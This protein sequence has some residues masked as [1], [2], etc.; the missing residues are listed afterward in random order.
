MLETCRKRV[1]VRRNL[2]AGLALFAVAATAP[3]LLHAQALP[4]GGSPDGVQAAVS[5]SLGDANLTSTNPFSFLLAGVGAEVYAP[6][7]RSIGAAGSFTLLETSNSGQ[8][9]PL[10]LIAFT[11]GPRYTLRTGLLNGRVRLYGQ[12]LVGGVEG[13]NGLFPK[14]GGATTGA[15]SIAFQT[16]GGI[17]IAFTH[18]TS[19][20]LVQAEWLR[21]GLPDA[22]QN[23]ENTLLLGFGVVYHFTAQ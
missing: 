20:R 22:T 16:G 18:R 23:V 21:T 10:H 13:F 12:G 17:D 11:G 4:S 1:Q 6:V 9:V 19:I 15:S 8:G 14:A 3:G 5:F 7:Y 2:L